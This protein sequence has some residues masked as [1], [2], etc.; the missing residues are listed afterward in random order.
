MIVLPDDDDY[1]DDDDGDTIIIATPE[2]KPNKAQFDWQV[3]TF[4]DHIA[5]LKK[6]LSTNLMRRDEPHMFLN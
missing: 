4:R 6:T 2:I 3:V 5:N 1:D